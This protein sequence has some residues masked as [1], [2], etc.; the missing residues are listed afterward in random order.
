[1]NKQVV[2]KLTKLMKPKNFP[3][4]ITVL[5]CTTTFEGYCSSWDSL[6]IIL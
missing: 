1:L 4:K 2:N 5:M 3:S 6:I